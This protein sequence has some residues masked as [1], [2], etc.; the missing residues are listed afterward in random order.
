M[1]A[2]TVAAPATSYFFGNKV[3]NTGLTCMT[4]SHA[5]LTAE[6]DEANDTVE[7]G[8][9][10]AGVIVV[11]FFNKVADL[12][13]GTALRQTIKIGT[14]AILTAD[15]LAAGGGGEA[16]AITPYKTGT[17]P[18]LVSVVTSTGAT[19]HQAGTQYLTF[20]YYSGE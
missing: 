2:A 1:T 3:P 19:G 12:D 17:A 10:P 6:T 13:S 11:G 4:L 8:Y 16:W 18:A 14:T 5:W 20:L 15:D 7:F 9:L